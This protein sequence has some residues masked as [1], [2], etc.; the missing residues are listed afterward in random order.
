LRCAYEKYGLYIIQHSGLKVA[1]LQGLNH[2]P[3]SPTKIGETVAIIMDA[4]SQ[5]VD[6]LQ[7]IILQFPIEEARMHLQ[8]N[9]LAIFK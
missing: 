9:C 8:A 4:F 2:I 5:L 3:L 6:I 1:L 7:L